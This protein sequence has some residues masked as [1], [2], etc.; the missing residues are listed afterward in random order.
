MTAPLTPPCRVIVVGKSLSALV[1]GISGASGARTLSHEKVQL[2]GSDSTTKG[3]FSFRLGDTETA[4]PTDSPP[5]EL[6]ET[7][8]KAIK[9]ADKTD[10]K[11]WVL[12]GFPRNPSELTLLLD[13]AVVPNA[14]VV[15]GSDLIVEAAVTGEKPLAG[16]VALAQSLGISTTT[17]ETPPEVPP[18]TPSKS[19][20]NPETTDAWHGMFSLSSG[21]EQVLAT[22]RS[23]D[24]LAMMPYAE[25]HDLDADD[26]DADARYGNTRQYCPVA[27]SVDHVLRTGLPSLAVNR[28]GRWYHMSSDD[29]RDKFIDTP[30][31]FV[32]DTP[33]VIP[34]PRICVLGPS[35]SGKVR[36]TDNCHPL[37]SG[38]SSYIVTCTEINTFVPRHTLAYPRTLAYPHTIVPAYPQ[39]S[40]ILS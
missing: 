7:I 17:I 36:Q 16:M 37:E 13:R 15:L 39:S 26:P 35:G 21:V 31:K 9:M 32:K 33:P 8:V 30:L 20:Q 40:I 25:D 3:T 4:V 34:P 2:D 29:A 38:K 19:K 23:K 18:P 14:L 1:G 11:G 22:A 5:D 6:A 10:S 24:P 28:N 27:L 12:H